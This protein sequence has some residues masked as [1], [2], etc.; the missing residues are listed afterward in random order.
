MGQATQRIRDTIHYLASQISLGWNC[1]LVSKFIREAYERDKIKG[2]H[3]ILKNAQLACWDSAILA[4][5]KVL[6][7][8]EGSISLNYL[9]NC[10]QAEPDSYPVADKTE[11]SKQITDHRKELDNLHAILP[12]LW[13]Q[14][15]RVVAHLDKRLV[16]KPENTF[17]QPAINMD[18]LHSV[19]GTLQR[20][21][22]V[23]DK[24]AQTMS[25]WIDES[26]PIWDDL[27]YL[28]GLINADKTDSAG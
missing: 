1:F 28:I 23:Y 22:E 10:I 20:I 15:D 9:F 7:K 26:Q 21:L 5:A 25:L 27:E 18:Q 2:V 24:Q 3:T 6:D 13:E 16:N 8:H 14:R 4:V 12:S 17:S 19:F 11:L